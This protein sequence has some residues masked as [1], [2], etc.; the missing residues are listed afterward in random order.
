VAAAAAA[1]AGV[2]TDVDVVSAE[3]DGRTDG[4]V[5]QIIARRRAGDH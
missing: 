5:N 2:D 3:T 4:R 1:A